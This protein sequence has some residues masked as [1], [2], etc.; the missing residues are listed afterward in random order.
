MIMIRLQEVLGDHVRSKTW[1]IV[2][3]LCRLAAV[4]TRP[5]TDT[6]ACYAAVPALLS[7]VDA[8]NCW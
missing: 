7:A 2:I 1:V 8:N 5:T 3:T 4:E 6:M